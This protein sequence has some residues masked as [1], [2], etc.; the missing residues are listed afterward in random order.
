MKRTRDK[1]KVERDPNQILQPPDPMCKPYIPLTCIDAFE[2]LLKRS[3]KLKEFFENFAEN[4]NRALKFCKSNWHF[5]VGLEWFLFNMVKDQ[6]ITQ[7]FN[8][9]DKK[10]A[11]KIEG[12]VKEKVNRFFEYEQTEAKLAQS[13]RDYDKELKSYVGRVLERTKELNGFFDN[14]TVDEDETVAIQA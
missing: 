2:V 4:Q 9:L 10:T 13:F 1:T 5:R 12:F 8:S 6:E 11:K 3:K 7:E 14:F